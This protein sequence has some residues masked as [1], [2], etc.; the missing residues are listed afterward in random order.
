[1][2]S[3]YEEILDSGGPA[4][5][6]PVRAKRPRI[7]ATGDSF[8][9]VS[10]PK[11]LK[12]ISLYASSYPKPSPKKTCAFCHLPGDIRECEGKLMGPFRSTR[13]DGTPGKSFYAHRNCA[14]WA[15]ETYVGKGRRLQ[16]V[17][18]ALGRSK[19]KK[20]S[21]CSDFGASLACMY[22]N[23]A[24][25][26]PMHFRCALL[27]GGSL[28]IGYNT[29]C[30]KHAKCSRSG[31]GEPPPFEDYVE[32]TPIRHQFL[33]DGTGCELCDGDTY[34]ADRGAVLTCS[35][36]CKRQHSKCVFP[37]LE[38]DLT[39]AARSWQGKY[40]CKNC[41]KCFKCEEA[42]D[43]DVYTMREGFDANEDDD[44]PHCDTVKCISCKHSA[45]HVACLPPGASRSLWRCDMCR[46][47]RHCH[48]INIPREKWNERYEACPACAAEIRKGG[49]VC[50]V[51]MKV[52]REGENL[53]MVQC[54]YCD[55]W[56]H[57]DACGGMSEK[58]F[59]EMGQS[60]AKYRCPICVKEKKKRD[61]ERRRSK[62]SAN[63]EKYAG[64][65]E[66]QDMCR[67]D[68]DA[69]LKQIPVEEDG[70]GFFSVRKATTQGH[71]L[72]RVFEDL[73]LDTELCRYCCSSGRK[74][75]MVFCVDCGECYH[76]ICHAA[77]AGSILPGLDKKVPSTRTE[78]G[79][80][81]SG[82]LGYGR[83][84]DV[85]RC[86][87][88]DSFSELCGNDAKQI[89]RYRTGSNGLLPASH[90]QQVYKEESSIRTNGYEMAL[91]N[92]LRV[93]GHTN[94]YS[95]NEADENLSADDA[96]F[97]RA[98]WEDHRTCELCGKGEALGAVEGRL[99]PWASST[100]ADIS[101]SWLHIAC[102]MWSNG[103]SIHGSSEY[104]DIL[105][106]PRRY[107]LSRARRKQCVCCQKNGASLRCVYPLCENVYHF[108]CA[109]E[110]DVGCVV[111]TP[112]EKLARFFRVANLLA[113]KPFE[114]AQVHSLR[115]LCPSHKR[116]DRD[117]EERMP[118][119]TDI[120]KH[121]NLKRAIKL[122]DGQGF[123]P[124]AEPPRKKR[125]SQDRLLSMR[126]GSLSVLHCGQLVPEVNDFI[127]KGCLVPLG[128]CAARR[129]WSVSDPYRRCVYLM[130]VCGHPQSGPL[131][132]IRCSDAPTWTVESQ[133]PDRAWHTV[134]E[135]V[136]LSRIR[137]RVTS[138]T[139]PPTHT[140]GLEAFGLSNCI[141]VVAH[142]ESLPMA[143]MF[144]GR[145]SHKRVVTHR[146][147]EITF[148]NTLAKKYKP[149]STPE[150]E[151]GCARTEGYL[152][153]SCV[154]EME[155]G[156]AQRLSVY[157]NARTGSA[158]Q[159]QVAREVF[160]KIEGLRSLH[161][162]IPSKEK[163]R[164]KLTPVAKAS[165]SSRNAKTKSAPNQALVTEHMG[166]AASSKAR[167]VVLRSDIDGL[168]V[169][170]TEDIPAGEMIIEYVGEMIRPSISD[171]REKKYCEKGIGCYMFEIVAG[172][173]VDAT[174]SGNAARYINH[175]CAPN[176]YSKTVSLENNRRV[177]V[178][179]A[180]RR[181]Q[182]G[183]ELSYDYKFPLD[184]SDRVKCECG[185]AQ[186]KG[187][188]N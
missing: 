25:C 151:T 67:A 142:I 119:M 167:T 140:T 40:Q 179:F 100:I 5:H 66:R 143:A 53:P 103:I 55:K 136:R 7:I 29:F 159:L 132:V 173:I 152:P 22:K 33:N 95:E 50:P 26:R 176:C 31:M 84:I 181:I 96:N 59:K 36:C 24:C 2:E 46:I 128:Y 56:I 76:E 165:S 133:D 32:N 155:L 79:A 108:G 11:R 112:S 99:I 71:S 91:C 30:P 121:L 129:Y 52:Y 153:K 135:T 17:D 146:N 183:E 19:R 45:I 48:V 94:G 180:K 177:V 68:L 3:E 89:P 125:F 81:E 35:Y 6:R 106:G 182:R 57:A 85:W 64:Y 160:A 157:E 184:D 87:Q 47:C 164:A 116:M 98:T 163:I 28:R 148:Y 37:G 44:E 82:H 104:A 18:L 69:I 92:E 110:V 178:I 172:Q 1:M 13:R 63:Q 130:E 123:S 162:K 138:P 175:S 171:I 186:C 62:E 39:F 169:F 111:N 156:S 43:L 115:I 139:V 170:A 72:D 102:V 23:T 4:P 10:A 88:C 168:G 187:F 188:M 161:G 20:C 109:R 97:E 166:I 8:G 15:P 12:N 34:D 14:L 118:C 114:L 126:I 154:R 144:N 113:C 83:N 38:R 75:E 9:V 27:G 90:R 58:K 127:V 70:V 41:V 158:F 16:D 49:V 105:L 137:A 107:L 51:C 122:F 73:S 149:V 80:S 147:N 124:D 134:T 174:M 145:Y 117:V 65:G 120:Q 185:A 77:K 78:I 74:E 21:L 131:F 93:N 61:A 86:F 101:S 141:P 42:V 150:N 60:D 54:D